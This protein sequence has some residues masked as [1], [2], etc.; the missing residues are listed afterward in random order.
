MGTG[1]SQWAERRFRDVSISIVPYDQSKVSAAGVERPPT[2]NLPSVLSL[3]PGANVSDFIM[4]SVTV[5]RSCPDSLFSAR[6]KARI[7]IEC[8]GGTKRRTA[9]AFVASESLLTAP[10]VQVVSAPQGRDGRFMTRSGRT[11]TET[12]LLRCRFSPSLS[13]LWL[14]YTPEMGLLRF[15]SPAFTY[16][17]PL[18]KRGERVTRYL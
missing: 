8:G 14:N 15:M 9:G 16:T 4:Q 11:E 12:F 6:A 13:A 2:F 7:S 10:V 5:V 18:V 1:E 3:A 17:Y